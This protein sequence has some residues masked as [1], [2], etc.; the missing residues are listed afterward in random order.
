MSDFLHGCWGLRL[1]ASCPQAC[2]IR[3]LTYWA[4]SPD[5]G[6][7]ALNSPQSMKEDFHLCGRLWSGLEFLIHSYKIW[8]C[9]GSSVMEHLG[10]PIPQRS[11]EAKL[12]TFAVLIKNILFWVFFPH[13]GWKDYLVVKITPCSCRGHEFSSQCSHQVISSPG[14]PAPCFCLSSAHN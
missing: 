2:R 8:G 7:L 11:E 9:G 6:W 4:I 10:S 3:T 13:W 12:V 14:D 1:R 5:K